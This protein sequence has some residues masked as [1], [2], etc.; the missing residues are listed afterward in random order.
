MKPRYVDV[1]ISHKSDDKDKA[2]RL[3]TRIVDTYEIG[4]AHI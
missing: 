1:F 4:R 3:K 2:Q